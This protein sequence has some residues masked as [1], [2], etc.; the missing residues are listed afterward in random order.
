MLSVNVYKTFFPKMLSDFS[1]KVE[2]NT[3]VAAKCRFKS[4]LNDDGASKN[5]RLYLVL[6]YSRCYYHS[7]GIVLIVW[8][9]NVLY[10]KFK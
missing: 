5:C 9:V 1:S 10:K 6:T 7:Y 4:R 8:I 3:Q 2:T